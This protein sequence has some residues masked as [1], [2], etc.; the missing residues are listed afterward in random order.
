MVAEG[1][2]AGLEG[3]EGTTAGGLAGVQGIGRVAGQ[4]RVV[5]MGDERVGVEGRGEEGTCGCLALHA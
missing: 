4:A 5:D 3:E 2:P 1:L